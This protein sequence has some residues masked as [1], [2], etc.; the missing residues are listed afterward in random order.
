[1][2]TYSSRRK[3]IATVLFVADSRYRIPVRQARNYLFSVSEEKRRIGPSPFHRPA[4]ERRGLSATEIAKNF[5]DEIRG[6]DQFE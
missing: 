1:M 4:M 2:S 6:R 5:R 3:Y